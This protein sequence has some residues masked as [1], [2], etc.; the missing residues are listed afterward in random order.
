MAHKKN[1]KNKMD[2]KL[3]R[4]LVLLAILAV[5]CVFLSAVTDT[6][7][8]LQT[9]QNVIRQISVQSIV[10]IGM[11][12]LILTGG[13]DLS[14]GTNLML[15]G[16]IGAVA[17]NATGSAAFGFLACIGTG[18]LIGAAN[19]L[20]VGY[21][22]ISP[23]MVTLAMQYACKGIGWTISNAT[24]IMVND[25]EA[26]IWL[27][28]ENI[29][30]GEQFALPVAFFAILL[31]YLLS[32]VMLNRTI[33]GKKVYAVGGSRAASEASGI[34]VKL[35]LL[36]CYA[37]AGLCVGIAAIISVGRTVSSQP[38]AG[39]GMEFDAITA[40][41][42]GGIAL[43][44]GMGSLA[45][46]LIG[47]V[48]VG[49]ISFGLGQMDISPYVQYV[50]K[51]A[52]ILAAVAADADGYI[53]Q[54]VRNRIS[55]KNQMG[56]TAAVN[57]EEKSASDFS[58]SEPHSE[59]KMEG[60]CKAFSG[61]Q[62]LKNVSFTIKRGK[63]HAL[64]GENGAGKSTLIK[65]LS[66]TYSKDLGTISVDGIPYGIKSVRD[67]QQI[68]ISVIYQEMSQVGEL[69]VAQ[70]IYLGKEFISN[71]HITVDRKKIN[72]FADQ[73]LKKLGLEID[74][75]KKI[76]DL[77]VG[78]QQMVEIVKAYASESWIIVMDEPTSAITDSDK[79]R[80]FELVDELK[81]QNVAI[82][83]ITHRMAEIFQIADEITVLRDGEHVKTT[84]LEGVSE[85]DIVRWMV[86]RD[87]GNI[88]KRSKRA[89]KDVIL[90]VRHLTRKGVFE[91]VNFKVHAGEVVGVSGLI[92][93]GRTEVM[94]CVF[95]LDKYDSGEILFMG[96]RVSFK[97][98]MDAIR[99]GVSYVPEDRRRESII[100][101]M[102]VLDNMS[103]ASLPW[104]N[105]HGF[106]QNK[107][108]T[109][110][111]MPYVGRFAIKMSSLAQH[112]TFLSGGNQQKAILAKWLS[113]NPRLIILDEPTRG[114]DVAA[115]ADIY[116]V[117]DDL[118]KENCA[119]IMVSSEM[120]EIL[121]I[122]DTIMVMHEGR[123]TGWLENTA[124]MTQEKIMSFAAGTF[125]KSA[126][127]N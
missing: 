52:I 23:F 72:E 117:I 60:I 24:R 122:S 66:G 35:T 120:A 61:V 6:F 56:N 25:N 2:E 104:L 74:V 49:V 20:M 1:N 77:T 82:V 32:S 45:G 100:P 76:K 110:T 75:N 108:V 3:T 57:I 119:V 42:I 84:S 43:N 126:S 96:K 10:A 95:G 89:A 53:M 111:Y 65:I 12:V 64:A 30:I 123:Q 13:I 70:N 107:K 81:R 121:G 92:G 67:A 109:D 51:G 80:L 54:S 116:Q 7:L 68:G 9:V 11:T 79:E 115:K 17:V 103:L 5:V 4:Y 114:I 18:T 97:C 73:Y 21:S 101:R 90:E 59:L 124:E 44:G 88:F 34:N 33:F 91:D 41:V 8:S 105:R 39:N 26:F 31:A 93:A 98:P 28:Q 50:V 106:V 38:L 46:T 37:F 112:I 48:M 83:Y 58:R 127:E 118:A 99:Q 94:R 15:C 78:Q 16:V 29:R 69:T 113:R 87:L 40:A 55:V 63:V 47:S 14:V 102:S 86:G 22:G 125:P 85:S 62:V 71:N 19:G 27:G 36:L